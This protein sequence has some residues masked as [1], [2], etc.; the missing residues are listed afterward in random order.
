MRKYENWKG[1]LMPLHVYLRREDVP[2][3]MNIIEEN[4]AFFDGMTLLQ[5]DAVTESVLRDIDGAEYNSQDTFIGRE[6]WLGA[7]NKSYLSTGAKTILNIKE[8][9][10]RCFSVIECGNN[11][12]KELSL[13]H[14]GHVFFAGRVCASGKELPCDIEMNGKRYDDFIEFTGGIMMAMKE[15]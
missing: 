9:P 12:L 14:D 7:L 15:E 8:Y 11:A 1:V 3:G 10:E 5:K 2:V 4:D 13:L 6:Q